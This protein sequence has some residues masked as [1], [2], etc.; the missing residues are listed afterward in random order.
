ML[1][2]FIIIFILLVNLNALEKL[3]V[4]VLAYGTVN[5]ELDTLKYYKLDK[6]NGFDLEVVKLASKNATSIALQ[7]KEVDIIVTDWL[8][9]NTQRANGKKY[10]LY[11][12]SRS[13]GTILIPKD[14]KAKTFLDLEGKNLG[15]AGGPVD[16]TWLLLRAYSK[17]KYGKDLAD[18]VKPTF[19]SPPIIYKNFLDAR[20]DSAIN[21]WHF[22]SKLK[23]KGAKEL[24]SIKEVLGELGIKKDIVFIGWTID[25]VKAE[26]NPNLFNSFI[27]ASH[28]AKDVL[29][30]SDNAWDRLRKGMKA[31]S[32]G[33]YESLKAG[34]RAGVIKE[35][36]Q[37]NIKELEKVYNILLKEG[38]AKL[39]GSSKALDKKTFWEYK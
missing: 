25:R 4:G 34:Y 37:E 39:V 23:A 26:Q 10:T 18:I 9:V 16:K 15:V 36:G 21:F 24:V 35:F 22:N 29:L 3:K 33:V 31:K 8:W 11:P 13:N 1:K 38:G 14:S 27:K 6:K 32:D 2:S 20:V 5:W 17:K 12:Y 19:S 30:N 7:A 28:E